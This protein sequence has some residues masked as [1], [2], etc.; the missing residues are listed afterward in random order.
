MKFIRDIINEKRAAKTLAPT[1]WPKAE[2]G[3]EPASPVSPDPFKDM[4]QEAPPTRDWSILCEAADNLDIEQDQPEA[5][6]EDHVAQDSSFE[7]LLVLDDPHVEWS[8]QFASDEEP[9]QDED[10][11]PDENADF[12]GT[13]SRFGRAM[14][15]GT[16]RTS[17][18]QWTRLRL[19]TGTSRSTKGSSD[20]RPNAAIP[21]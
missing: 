2:E 1:L 19:I 4:T 5:T 7:D 8:G 6:S 10:D 3:E 11:F 21:S 9:A 17:R 15:A 20:L 18:T 12:G 16:G 13:A 14:D